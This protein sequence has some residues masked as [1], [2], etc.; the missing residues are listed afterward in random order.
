MRIAAAFRSITPT[1]CRSVCALSAAIRPAVESARLPSIPGCRDCPAPINRAPGYETGSIMKQAQ[2]HN[3]NGAMMLDRFR[4]WRRLLVS[5]TFVLLAAL[6]WPTIAS[7]QQV[8]VI[9]N[10]EPITALDI[11]QRSKLTQ[12]STHKAPSRQEIIDELINER[13]KVR[14]AKKWGLEVP[15]SEV[16]AAYATMASRMRRTA[17][18]LTQELAKAGVNAATLKARIRAD[19]AW[20]QL[21]RGRYQASL[22]IGEKDILTAMDSKS[23][24]TVGY[25]YILRPILFLVPPGSPEVFIDGRKREAEALR[26]RFQGCEEGI[27]FAH[28]LKDVAV[29]EQVTRSSADI[30][31]EL[32]KVLESVEVGRLTA[33]EATKL[34]IE[35]FA[36]CA[37]KASAADNTPGKR[38]ARDTIMNERY[39]Q[40]S[41]Q[42]LQEL[43]RGAMF[44]YK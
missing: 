2:R 4:T 20:P 6:A 13:L 38:Q 5:A 16:D 31:A 9:V 17:E 36:I 11:E 39:E 30:P 32:R 19:I 35:M 23:D 37:K 43:R 34:G 24:D 44:E 3:G 21:V 15:N 25:D 41:K 22:Q 8:V 18:Q 42:W 27:A 33:P 28:A 1:C 12:L 10:G 40:R 26:S 7:A 29:R 14:E